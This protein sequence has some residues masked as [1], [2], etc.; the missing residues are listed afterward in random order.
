MKV[1]DIKKCLVADSRE[2]ETQFY[3]GKQA[4]AILESAGMDE[5][6]LS[7]TIRYA[8]EDSTYWTPAREVYFI[9]IEELDEGGLYLKAVLVS[10]ER[11]QE[12][13][14]EQDAAKSSTGLGRGYAKRK[15]VVKIDASTGEVVEIYETFQEAFRAAKVSNS[16]MRR[17]ILAHEPIDGYLYEYER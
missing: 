9:S 6:L 12:E 1:S 17:C 14:M 3:L 7:K 10:K 16:R 11:V 8:R 15:P 4:M 2:P 5:K 13:R